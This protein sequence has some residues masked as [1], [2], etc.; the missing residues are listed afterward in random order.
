MKKT[1]VQ[2][3]DSVENYGWHQVSYVCF[4]AFFGESIAA[5]VLYIVSI[6]AAA[7]VSILYSYLFYKKKMAAGEKIKNPV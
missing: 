1:G 3:I 7:I 6:M 2:L 4:A 5:L